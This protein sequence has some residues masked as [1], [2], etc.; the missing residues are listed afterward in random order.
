MSGTNNKERQEE[1]IKVLSDM[2]QTNIAC[3]L[4]KELFSLRLE[5][6]KVELI[7]EDNPNYR[8]RAQELTELL[9]KIF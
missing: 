8:G 4:F 5:K 3:S 7:K 9:G 6:F 2:G 1:I